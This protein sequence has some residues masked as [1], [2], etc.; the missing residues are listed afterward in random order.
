MFAKVQAFN[1]MNNNLPLKAAGAFVG[2]AI[3]AVLVAVALS[4]IEA[5]EDEAFVSFEPVSA[6]E[7]E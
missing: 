1:A 7:S 6:E 3:G 5:D 4:L 2:A